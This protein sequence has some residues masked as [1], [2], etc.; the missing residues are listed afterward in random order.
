MRRRAALGGSLV[1]P[2]PRRLLTSPPQ[3]RQMPVKT[4][5]V[6]TGVPQAQIVKAAAQVRG[7]RRRALDRRSSLP[8]QQLTHPPPLP[9]S[10]ATR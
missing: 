6:R 2:P 3:P 10:S 5:N 8:P 1:P 7:R 4:A 9:H